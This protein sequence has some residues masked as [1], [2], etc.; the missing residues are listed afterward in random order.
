MSDSDTM[1]DAEPSVLTFMESLADDGPLLAEFRASPDDV[2]SK[3][4]LS[5][6]DQELILSGD[7]NAL[8]KTVE[9]EPGVHTS[10]FL[11]IVIII[12]NR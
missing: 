8:R 4:G 6:D 9:A 5:M 2:L 1:E 3:S 7:P 12:I 11:L 10:A